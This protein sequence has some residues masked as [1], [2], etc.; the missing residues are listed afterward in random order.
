[1]ADA[2]A[3]ATHRDADSE[4]ASA[5]LEMHKR[6]HC[7]WLVVFLFGSL[8]ELQ[9]NAGHAVYDMAVEHSKRRATETAELTRLRVQPSSV[10][11]AATTGMRKKPVADSP[12]GGL[13]K[14][15]KKPKANRSARKDKTPPK[16]PLSTLKRKDGGKRLSLSALVKKKRSSAE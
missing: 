3:P 14:L 13:A 1:M 12:L 9:I 10:A 4:R 7:D 16:Q 15:R 11:G 2:V 6:R 8:Y 5:E